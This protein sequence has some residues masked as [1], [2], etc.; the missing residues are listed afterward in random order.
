[1]EFVVALRD[2]SRGEVPEVDTWT[3]RAVLRNCPRDVFYKV[4]EQ[5]PPLPPEKRTVK[6]TD[7]WPFTISKQQAASELALGE[8]RDSNYDRD[9]GWVAVNVGNE[10]ARPSTAP[11]NAAWQ[12]LLQAGENSANKRMF[13]EK[14]WKSV[15]ER[16]QKVDEETVQRRSEIQQFSL[17]DQFEGWKHC[18]HCGG[19]I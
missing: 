7:E 19:D 3:P 2:A 13:Y 9:V 1:M 14:H 11:S 17:L 12:L 6:P 18:P 10:E 15:E 8:H 4:L 5:Y 16:K